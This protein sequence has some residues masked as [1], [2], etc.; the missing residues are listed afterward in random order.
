MDY[1]TKC[2]M[3]LESFQ[4]IEEIHHKLGTD[5]EFLEMIPKAQ[6]KK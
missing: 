4:N 3:L 6:A 5:N 1:G 2:K